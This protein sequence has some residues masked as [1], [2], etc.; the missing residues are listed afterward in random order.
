MKA[1]A[2]YILLG[3]SGAMAFDS[4]AWLEKRRRTDGDAARLRAAWS[5]CAERA[6][7][8]AMGLEFPLSTHPD[9]SPKQMLKAR[10]AQ[11][12]VEEGL[13]WAEGVEAFVFDESGAQVASAQV[14]S[15][16]VDRKAKRAW[17]E[18]TARVEWSGGSL[19]GEGFY[20]SQDDAFAKIASASVLSA[21]VRGRGL[22]AVAGAAGRKGVGK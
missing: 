10:K 12:F 19:C 3:T 18:G 13:V 8:P 16:V 15:C 22:A 11:L 14:E 7:S 1:L 4:Q 6:V 17:G 20:I 2:A 9:G 5:N 21:K